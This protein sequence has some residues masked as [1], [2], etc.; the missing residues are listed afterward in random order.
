M[1]DQ[2]ENTPALS[3]EP[4][5]A[6][7]QNNFGETAEG[8]KRLFVIFGLAHDVRFAAILCWSFFAVYIFFALTFDSVYSFI[9]QKTSEQFGQAILFIVFCGFL[10][11]GLLQL[12]ATAARYKNLGK[13]EKIFASVT[14]I[15]LLGII[16]SIVI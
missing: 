11:C 13:K 12:V 10:I 4:Q 8:R 5:T 9:T 2:V 1:E 3:Q 7:A 14:A 16:I 6:P 15:I